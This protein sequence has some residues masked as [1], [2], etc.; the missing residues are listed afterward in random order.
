M[1]IFQYILLYYS[2]LYLLGVIFIFTMIYEEFQ[3]HIELNYSIINK[4]YIINK[5]M[6]RF[7]LMPSISL[8][9]L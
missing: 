7:V 1:I 3:L 8:F 6:D 9:S 2:F 5:L 4:L